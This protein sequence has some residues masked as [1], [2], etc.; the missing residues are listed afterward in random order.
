M[1]Y[2]VTSTSGSGPLLWTDTEKRFRIIMYHKLTPLITG[3]GY[4]L[5]IPKYIP[6]FEG[7]LKEELEIKPAIIYRL[8]TGEEWKH[9]YQLMIHKNIH[10]KTIHNINILHENIWQ[11]NGHL[12][13]AKKIKEK[14]ALLS[15]GELQF[16]Q[17]FSHFG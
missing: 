3:P 12:F 13:V 5:I 10:P 7:L 15:S 2:H 11:Y 16:S 1:I 14:L 6:A 17:G 4:T 9:Y 8:A